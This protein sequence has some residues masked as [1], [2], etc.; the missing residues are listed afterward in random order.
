MIR[1]VH[2]KT[3]I[4]YETLDGVYNMHRL[5]SGRWIQAFWNESAGQWQSYDVVDAL[6]EAGGS[7]YVARSLEALAPS[8]RTYRRPSDV[9]RSRW[10]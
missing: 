1:R 4:E 2:S 5:A 7:G 9:L 8:V 3:N 10:E 6:R